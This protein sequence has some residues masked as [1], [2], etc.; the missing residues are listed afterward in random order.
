MAEEFYVGEKVKIK[1]HKNRKY[2]GKTGKLVRKGAMTT[3]G[4]LIWVVSLESP[5]EDVHC[6]EEQLELVLPW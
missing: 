4:K 2:V 5:K 6:Y 3:P 1:E